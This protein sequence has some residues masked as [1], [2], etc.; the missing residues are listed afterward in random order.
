[1]TP[2][3]DQ[4]RT[5]DLVVI[6][7]EECPGGDHGVIWHPGRLFGALVLYCKVCGTLLAIQADDGDSPYDDH[8]RAVLD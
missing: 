7:A 1:M 5:R 3:T 8:M 2:M 4:I 6:E